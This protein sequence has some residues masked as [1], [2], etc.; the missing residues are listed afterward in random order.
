MSR[1]LGES[2]ALDYSDYHEFSHVSTCEEA[3]M[4]YYNNRIGIKIAKSN[5]N[6][7]T[8]CVENKDLRILEEEE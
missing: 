2:R 5:L 6:C 1:E 8:S 7:L 3:R 4:D